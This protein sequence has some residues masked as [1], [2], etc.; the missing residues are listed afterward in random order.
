MRKSFSFLFILMVV[1]WVSNSVCGLQ[2]RLYPLAFSSSVSSQLWEIRD[3]VIPTFDKIEWLEDGVHP[4]PPSWIS[5]GGWYEAHSRQIL[6]KSGN[7]IFAT[8]SESLNWSA[9]SASLEMEGFYFEAFDDFKSLLCNDQAWWLM[10]SWGL[11]SDWLGISPNTTRVTAEFDPN[12]SVAFI[13]MSCHITNIPEY[14]LQIAGRPGEIGIGAEKLPKP[15]F[16]AFDLAAIYIGD[17]DA[18]QLYEDYE[19]DHRH[20]RI[21]FKAPATLLSQC[22]DTYSVSLEVSPPHVGET[23]NAYRSMNISM[24]SDTE[25]RNTSP[26]NI[27]TGIDNIAMFGLS[28]SD[29]YPHSFQV[30]SGPPVQDLTEF[31][32][33]N[34]VRW[35][36]EPEIWVA[37]GTAIIGIYAGFHGKRMW[38]RQKTYYRLYR[39]MINLWDHY[40]NNLSKFN[41]EIKDLSKSITKYFIDGK[42]NDDQFDKLLTRRDGLLERAKKLEKGD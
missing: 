29:R 9:V 5:D 22:M 12:T 32:I 34:T 19:I 33:E 23:H 4:E 25:I 30:T 17:F 28:D 24:P 20:Y 42:I 7:Y 40:S 39:S 8:F 13:E 14:F 31:L 16:A 10:Y 38:S 3:T 27:S 18:L 6:V 2:R 35:A 41:Q 37:L 11:P 21:Y 1:A 15:L 36:T 26:S